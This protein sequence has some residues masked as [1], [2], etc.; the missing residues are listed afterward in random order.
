MRV[1]RLPRGHELPDGLR[2]Q[3]GEISKIAVARPP[4][5]LDKA[6]R[7]DHPLPRRVGETLLGLLALLVLAVPAGE[8][9]S[10]LV[11]GELVHR[12]DAGLGDRPAAPLGHPADGAGP[13]RDEPQVGVEAAVAARVQ[14]ELTRVQLHRA[15]DTRDGVLGRERRCGVPQQL[16]QHPDEQSATQLLVVV[17]HRASL[18][19]IS[20]HLT[21]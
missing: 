17:T 21:R 15:L 7:G 4:A 6:H 14:A 5:R 1:L 16:E 3:A 2:G 20:R 11:A 8:L 18:P 9:A 19:T 13:R 10:E 12:F